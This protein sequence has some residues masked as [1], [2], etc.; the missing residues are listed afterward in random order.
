MILSVIVYNHNLTRGQWA[1]AAVVF[2]GIGVEAAAKRKGNP[3]IFPLP[4]QVTLT[5]CSLDIHAKQ[6]AQE[7]EKARIKSL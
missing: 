3:R 2:A 7:K 1:G 4:L 5:G 6:V